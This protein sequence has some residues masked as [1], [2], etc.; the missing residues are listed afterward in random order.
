MKAMKT[1]RN[2]RL[3]AAKDVEDKGEGG[4]GLEKEEVAWKRWGKGHRNGA[5]VAPSY[6]FLLYYSMSQCQ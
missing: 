1:D 6:N 3:D 2:S 5:I 4:E